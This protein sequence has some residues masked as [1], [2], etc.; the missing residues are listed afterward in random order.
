[1]PVA[2]Q[3]TYDVCPGPKLIPKFKKVVKVVIGKPINPNNIG[4][5]RNMETYLKIASEVK[6]DVK[7]LFK[8]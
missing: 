7:K 6:T 3:G 4:K 8:T 5:E 1:L 2:L